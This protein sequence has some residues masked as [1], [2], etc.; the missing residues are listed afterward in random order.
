[1]LGNMEMIQ[2]IFG[3]EII[4]HISVWGSCFCIV[5]LP[6]TTH[7]LTAG[8]VAR[9]AFRAHRRGPAVA[10]VVLVA[11]WHVWRGMT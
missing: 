3:V 4:L 7:A 1:M 2:H 10:L 8:H 6:H 5:S 11:V 9:T